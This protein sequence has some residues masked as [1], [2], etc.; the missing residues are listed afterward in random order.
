MQ[1]EPYLYT[2]YP[3]Y[4]QTFEEYAMP[5]VK[6][7]NAPPNAYIERPMPLGESL[8]WVSPHENHVQPNVKIFFV[9]SAYQKCVEH[10]LSDLEREVGGVL[11]GV[12]RR[13]SARA[14]TYIVI[15]DII[16]ATFTD[17]G[18]TH[19]TFTQNTLVHLNHQLEDQFP[20]KTIVG[21]YHTHPRLG[22]FLS[23]HDTFLH[24]HFFPEP[25]HVALVID[26]C[27]GNAGFFCWQAEQTLDPIHYVG[28]YELSDVD[29]HSIVEWENLAPAV[30]GN[31]LSEQEE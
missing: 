19:L 31:D 2:P 16:P 25:I 28:F 9:Q 7:S 29:E 23:S 14:Q 12:V 4:R 8:R 3:V 1:N 20:G 13:D 5:R 26:P 27:L 22:V 30:G 10:T 17:S 18:E 21:W 11:I 24:R 6:I 15:Q